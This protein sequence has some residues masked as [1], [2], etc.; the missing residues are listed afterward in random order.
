MDAPALQSL[1][2]A[3]L[4]TKHVESDD[5]IRSKQRV[6]TVYHP[7]CTC[8]MGADR[9]TA[10]VD[11]RLGVH[12]LEGLRIVDASVMPCLVR[13]NTNAPT[14]YDRGKGFPHD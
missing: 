7:A 13:A 9:S 5:G 2:K 11:A 14:T 4:F 6:D 10:V 12:C 8:Q 1:R 3:D